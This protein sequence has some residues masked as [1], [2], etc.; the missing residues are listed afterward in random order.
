[1][2]APSPESHLNARLALVHRFWALYQARRWVEAQA[3]LSPEAQCLWWATRE[4][5][6]GAAA[7]VQVNAVYPEGWTIRL[8]ELNDLGGARVHSLVRVDHGE[9][10]FY[11]NSF[12]QLQDGLIARLDEYWADSQPAPSWRTPDALPG[13]TVQPAD[14]RLGLDLRLPPP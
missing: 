12:F 5:F 4:R 2:P 11:A 14:Q 10:A 8:L 7:I 1:M 3:L 13:L 9:A 6:S